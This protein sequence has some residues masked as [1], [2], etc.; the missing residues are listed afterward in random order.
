LLNGVGVSITVCGQC[1]AFWI[2][3]LQSLIKK[4]TSQ[5]LLCTRITNIAS[6]SNRL[7]PWTRMATPLQRKLTAPGRQVGR[8]L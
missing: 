8:G 5:V 1:I 3:I 6:P 4:T 2:E 7:F